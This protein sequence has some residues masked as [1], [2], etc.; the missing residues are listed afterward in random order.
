MM[1]ERY[2]SELKSED[3]DARHLAVDKIATEASLDLEKSVP[4]LAALLKKSD[5]NTRWYVGRAFIKLGSAAI[6]Y[7]IAE[8]EKETDMVI[9]KY[10]ASVLAYFGEEAA[11]PLVK[12]FESENPTSRGMAAAALEKIGE[13]SIIYLM[14]TVSGDNKVASV[15]AGIVLAKLGVYD[16]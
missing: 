12:L 6:P 9:Q 15:C 16:Y 14:E 10:F 7:I 4:A 2:E 11:E 13:P 8:S 5:T 1:F 3:L